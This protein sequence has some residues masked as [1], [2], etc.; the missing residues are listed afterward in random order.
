MG[1]ARVRRTND[2]PP[3]Y[4]AQADCPRSEAL[5]LRS[6]PAFADAASREAPHRP[7]LALLFASHEP[8]TAIRVNR[9][10]GEGERI[11]AAT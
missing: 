3:H 1:G 10:R 5:E 9:E 4:P 8:P 2:H 7:E 6:S 11:R